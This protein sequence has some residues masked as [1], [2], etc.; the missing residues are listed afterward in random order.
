[1]NM[2]ADR[3]C[4]DQGRPPAGGAEETEQVP[5]ECEVQV[6]LLGG[7]CTGLGWEQMGIGVPVS[8]QATTLRPQ[9]VGRTGQDETGVCRKEW[10][11]R[12][13]EKA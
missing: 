12:G 7:G 4:H 3:G 5:V 8:R 6:G 10:V 13:G 1:M 2:R 9:T 11:R